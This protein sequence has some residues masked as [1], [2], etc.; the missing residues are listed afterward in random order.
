MVSLF[1][2]AF[3]TIPTNS[4]CLVS[5]TEIV[6]SIVAVLYPLLLS[7]VSYKNL[8]PLHPL[9]TIFPFK[10]Q[11]LWKQNVIKP[12]PTLFVHRKPLANVLI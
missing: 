3:M 11:F 10:T 8:T 9:I 2:C 5:Y 12:L 6:P 1:F 4:T 7:S